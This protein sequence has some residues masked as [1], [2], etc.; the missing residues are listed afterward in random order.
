MKVFLVAGARPNF[1]KIAPV[2]REALKHDQV[3]CQIVHTGQHYDYEMSEAFFKDLDIPEPDFFLNAGSGSHAVQTAKVMVAF[4]DLCEKERPDVVIVVGDVNSTLA[5][6][7]VAKKS[8]IKVAHVEAGLRSFDLTMPEEINRMVTDCLSDYFFVTEESGRENLLKEGK[9]KESIHFVGHV[10]IDNLLY[11]AKRLDEKTTKGFSTYPL[12]KEHNGYAFLTLHRPSNV[13]TKEA[14]SEIAGAL[15]EIAQERPLFFP[16][17]PRTAKMMQQFEMTLSENIVLLSPLGF[18]EAL[19]LW[20]D[21]AVV[22]TDSGGLQE[23]TTALG[24]PCVTLREN[25]ERPITIEMGTNVLG[26]TKKGSILKAYGEA[27]AR[28]EKRCSV[29]PKWDG[30]AS[31][32]IWKVLL[33]KA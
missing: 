26:G 9:G 21:A 12:K 17:H 22:L 4:E 2:Y 30:K 33:D 10:M 3:K 14:F 27:M 5:C 1:M 31:E 6:S 16:V 28:D 19:F 32:R 23:E 20:K 13:D 15:N 25:T 24:V 7:V 11:Q 18:K 29:P 8:L